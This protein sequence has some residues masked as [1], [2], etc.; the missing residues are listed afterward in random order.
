MFSKLIN[1]PD[2]ILF[3]LDTF[4]SKGGAY[5]LCSW[6]RLLKI[7]LLVREH[8]NVI[9][10]YSLSGKRQPACQ[11]W[12]FDR[13]WKQL[14]LYFEAKSPILL[15]SFVDFSIRQFLWN[16]LN[17]WLIGNIGQRVMFFQERVCDR[18]LKFCVEF[19]RVILL[20]KW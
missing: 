11:A 19:S 17:N 9:N 1:T 2:S 14:C 3:S 7:K 8:C 6:V 12:F 16:A 18:F 5:C 4:G 20:Q 13:W 10:F 15:F